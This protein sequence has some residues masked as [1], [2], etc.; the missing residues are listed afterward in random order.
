[1]KGKID[2]PTLAR[3]ALLLGIACDGANDNNNQKE[4][5]GQ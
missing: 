5:I 2:K 3:F 4:S 1:L